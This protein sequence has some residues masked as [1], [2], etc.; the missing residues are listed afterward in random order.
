MSAGGG[1]RAGAGGRGSGGRRSDIRL[2]NNVELLGVVASGVGFYRFEY[3]GSRTTYVGLIAQEVESVAPQAVH[4]GRDGYLRVDYRQLG[5]P[6]QTF[7]QWQERGSRIPAGNL[8]GSEH[9][10]PC[11]QFGRCSP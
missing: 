6:F 5:I 1:A 4:R 9:G 2:K 8:G 7:R 11:G 10:M 3:G